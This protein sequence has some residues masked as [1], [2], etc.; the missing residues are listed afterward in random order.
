M[1]IFVFA[2]V[3]FAVVSGAFGKAAKKLPIEC[4]FACSEI[5]APVCYK[6]LMNGSL[7]TF[8]NLCFARSANCPLA[9]EHYD[10]NIRNNIIQH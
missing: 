9:G 7:Q 10:K 2:L 8:S 3:I 6:N 5:W 1:K 4:A